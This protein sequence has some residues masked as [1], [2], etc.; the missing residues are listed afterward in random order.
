[1]E[2]HYE[3]KPIEEVEES[4]STEE[5]ETIEDSEDGL[6]YEDLIEENDMAIT[7]L[8]ELLIDKKIIT[9]DEYQNK[10]DEL[11]G[12]NEE[13]DIEEIEEENNSE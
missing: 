6:T 3:D 11:Y 7:A 13:D 12:S 10:Y 1:M 9:L 2:E 8:I 5:L 4:E